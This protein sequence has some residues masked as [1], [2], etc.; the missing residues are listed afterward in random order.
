[1]VPPPLRL[2][3]TAYYLGNEIID[4]G[5]L[6]AV[7]VVGGGDTG[8]QE[9]AYAHKKPVLAA[10]MAFFPAPC[11]MGKTRRDGTLRCSAN[12]TDP[13][14]PNNGPSYAFLSDAYNSPTRDPFACDSEPTGD[15]TGIAFAG[16]FG[17]ILF[18][19]IFGLTSQKLLEI[20]CD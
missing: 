4:S 9:V 13:A 2:G 8:L 7:V 14:S 17:I 16:I 3:A 20:N 12:K 18:A 1:M 11:E 10:N 6:K 5:S 19:G 15:K